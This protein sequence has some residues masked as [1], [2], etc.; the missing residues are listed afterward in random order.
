MSI[1]N[2]LQQAFN[3]RPAARRRHSTS[4]FIPPCAGKPRLI[5][6]MD[7]TDVGTATIFQI[8]WRAK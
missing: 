2:R 4:I 1:E 5:A 6:G 7:T 3:S 8:I